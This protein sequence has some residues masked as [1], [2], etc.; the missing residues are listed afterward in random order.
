MLGPGPSLLKAAP[1]PKCCAAVRL[2]QQDGAPEVRGAAEVMLMQGGPSA[3]FGA[4]V[5]VSS[6]VTSAAT[7]HIHHLAFTGSLTDDEG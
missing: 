5:T 7:V 4:R 6:A 3:Q 1:R 2:E